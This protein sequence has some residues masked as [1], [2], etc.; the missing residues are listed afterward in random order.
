VTNPDKSTCE[1]SLV[2]AD[3]FSGKGLGSR[4]MLSIMDMARSRGLAYIEGLVLNNNHSM[5]KLMRSLG[6]DVKAF[7]D[8][9]DFRL[10]VKAL[11]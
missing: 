8:D 7:E 10:C 3:E 6:F 11:Q 4:M 5:L 2:I 9:P 1:F